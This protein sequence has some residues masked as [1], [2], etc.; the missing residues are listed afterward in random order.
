MGKI[1][2]SKYYYLL[3][4]ANM[5]ILSWNVFS[6]ATQWPLK[7][8][9]CFLQAPSSAGRRGRRCTSSSV[10]S[11]SR[12]MGCSKN[13]QIFSLKEVSVRH[14]LCSPKCVIVDSRNP[15]ARLR[16][17]KIPFVPQFSPP[18][19]KFTMPLRLPGCYNSHPGAPLSPA[20]LP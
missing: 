2:T 10:T 8:S 9:R 18:S 17:K 16:L 4:T 11:E 12:L 6:K 5:N 1:N 7:E 14:Q 13:T 19:V 15:R 3:N 20:P